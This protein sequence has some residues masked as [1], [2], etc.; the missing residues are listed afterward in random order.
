MKNKKENAKI[1][2]KLTDLKEET[3]LISDECGEFELDD[4][5]LDMVVGGGKKNK[6]LKKKAW[7]QFQGFV[8]QMP[9]KDDGSWWTW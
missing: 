8:S 7:D 1:A 6:P 4:S 2:S 5:D 3:Q 9:M